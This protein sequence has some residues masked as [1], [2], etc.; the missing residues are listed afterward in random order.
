MALR[1]TLIAHE[2]PLQAIAVAFSFDERM[3]VDPWVR[4]GMKDQAVHAHLVEMPRDPGEVQ[5]DEI[6]VKKPRGIVGMT[7]AMM[8]SSRLCLAGE[9]SEHRNL[10]LIRRLVERVRACARTSPILS[11]IDGLYSDIREVC[12]PFRE[13]RCSVRRGRPQHRT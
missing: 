13:A 4:V 8:L 9:M 10:P 5:T 12:E 6:R 1:I 3:V 7:L 11:C 2:C